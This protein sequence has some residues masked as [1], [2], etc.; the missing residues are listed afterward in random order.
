MEQEP[1]VNSKK[2]ENI[3]NITVSGSVLA[4]LL[5]VSERR[6]RQLANEEIIIRF[7]KGRY[8]LP[9]SIKSYILYLKTNKESSEVTNDAE[10]DYKREQAFH[11][12]AKREKA[13]LELALMKGSMHH[14][15]DVERVMNDMLSSFKSKTLAM[16]TKLAP[17][18]IARN[19][20]SIIQ[21]LIKREALEVLEELSNYDPVLF[22]SD[23]YID[24]IDDEDQTLEE[25]VIPSD[26][27]TKEKRKNK[28]KND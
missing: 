13:E 1:S 18:L 26:G 16:A 19:E 14:S 28:T 20:I 9:E 3:D 8:N 27:K 24:Y 15:E 17:K 25:S 22:Y 6:I 23:K 12:K 7:R 21:D 10:I 5:N 11:E 4:N 2:I